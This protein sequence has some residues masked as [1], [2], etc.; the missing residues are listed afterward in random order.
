[1]EGGKEFYQGLAT[2]IETRDDFILSVQRNKL[3]FFGFLDEVFS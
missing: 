1:M 2:Y 3:S